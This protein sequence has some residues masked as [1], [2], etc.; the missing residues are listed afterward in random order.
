MF[1][2]NDGRHSVAMATNPGQTGGAEYSVPSACPEDG[3]PHPMI[4]NASRL[5][6]SS[7]RE[8]VGKGLGR[9]REGGGKGAGR[10]WGGT[11]GTDFRL[12]PS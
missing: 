7:G 9:W 3:I 6:T 4:H 12:H 10:G 11:E 8:G 2:E 5:V 1:G